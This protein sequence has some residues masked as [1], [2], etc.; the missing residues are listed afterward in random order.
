M[1]A[2][3][4]GPKERQLFGFHH[5]P[6]GGIGPATLL[7]APWAREYEYAHRSLGFLARQ[8]AAA[9]RHVLRFDL[10]CTGDS[11]GGS[12]E[13]DVDRWCEEIVEAADELRM[14]SGAQKL[15][16][17]GLRFGAYLMARALPRLANVGSVVL[18][19][20]IADGQAW[21]DELGLHPATGGRY[22]LGNTLVSEDFLTQVR[23]V[24]RADFEAGAPT[25]R[26]HLV[27]Q[28]D[29]DHATVLSGVEGLE[30]EF[31]EQPAP[32]V[33]DESIWTGQV[34]VA[35]VERIVAWLE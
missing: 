26:L 20:P 6:P 24:G 32:W 3:F 22:E 33:E 17:V 18:W 9:G 16:L 29:D 31:L 10:S 30:H 14:M 15:D 25:R 8:L 23:G 1:S 12:V 21:I 28:R 27:T 11:W 7:C 5:T 4:F 2:F 35:A 19:D 13:S 34:P